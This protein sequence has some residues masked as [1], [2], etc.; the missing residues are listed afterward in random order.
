M[1]KA[2]S[3][4]TQPGLAVVFA[5]AVLLLIGVAAICASKTVRV[6]G[7]DVASSVFAIK[8]VIV[9]LIAAACSIVV[10]RIGYLRISR[11]SYL[12]F[13]LCLALL[14]PLVLAKLFHTSFGGLVPSTRGAHRVDPVSRVAPAAIG[15]D[16][17]GLHIGPSLVPAVSKELSDVHRPCVPLRDVC[18]ANGL[19]S[20]TA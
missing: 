16:E 19:D 15:G 13:A 11:Y 9:A 2:T 20:F 17:G 14:V 4:L 5:V 10:L 8:Q 3:K 7:R 6:G 12:I 1:K 18:F